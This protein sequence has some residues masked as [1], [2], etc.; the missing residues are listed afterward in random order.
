MG[1][2]RAK[3]ALYM[4]AH[5]G[6]VELAAELMRMG[7]SASEPTGEHPYRQWTLDKSNKEKISPDYFKAPI[8]AA[9]DRGQLSIL[10]TMATHDQ[11]TLM[12]RYDG[13]LPMELSQ[14]KRHNKCFMFLI[15]KSW[16]KI[17]YADGLITLSIIHHMKQWAQKARTNVFLCYGAAKSTLRR[18]PALWAPLLTEGV[19]WDTPRQ[20][21]MD[22][23]KP[24]LTTNNPKYVTLPPINVAKLQQQASSA[25]PASRV[26][27]DALTSND[28]ECSAQE[29]RGS[30]VN[31]PSKMDAVAQAK[32]MRKA[33]AASRPMVAI[34]EEDETIRSRAGSIVI[35]GNSGNILVQTAIKNCANV[36]GVEKIMARPSIKLPR[37]VEDKQRYSEIGSNE[38]ENVEEKEANDDNKNEN[39]NSKTN[40]IRPVKYTRKRPLVR[41]LS[42]TMIQQ[43]F[44]E[45]KTEQNYGSASS[46][47]DAVFDDLQRR[48]TTMQTEESIAT[49][50][51]NVLD[52]RISKLRKARGRL[53][54]ISAAKAMTLLTVPEVAKG[55]EEKDEQ[56]QPDSDQEN[57]EETERPIYSNETARSSQISPENKQREKTVPKLAVSVSLPSPKSRNG[58]RPGEPPKSP[59]QRAISEHSNNVQVEKN[60]HSR[61]S[62]L[63]SQQTNQKPQMLR[64]KENTQNSVSSKKMTAKEKILADLI[65]HKSKTLACPIALPSGAAC[66]EWPRPWVNPRANNVTGN[67]LATLE[68]YNKH[69]RPD[70]DA[71]TA[72]IEQLYRANQFSS[73]KFLNR[74]RLAIEMSQRKVKQ[75]IGGDSDLF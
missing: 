12:A 23:T 16:K 25:I 35:G 22:I 29:S 21:K 20:Q 75:Q 1:N 26:S 14:R 37:I 55:N 28:N 45:L 48:S 24:L 64:K 3:V 56:E 41:N 51:S 7:F 9:A 10:R 57:W 61:Q 19:A 69:Y 2:F 74:V 36:I 6:H 62:T 27:S 49:R 66:E 65:A 33:I 73:L 67:P 40:T 60:G 43:L 70:K 44:D 30:D 34:D 31:D 54:K 13:M 52:S 59:V 58:S 32:W 15:A 39:I 42:A 47:T 5:F 71:R 38:G 4:A 11:S 18:R 53:S 68:L 46:S 63:I 17:Q 72:A 50:P 8:H